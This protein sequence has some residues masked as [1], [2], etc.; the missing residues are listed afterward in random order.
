[1]RLIQWLFGRFRNKPYSLEPTEA[2]R[3]LTDEA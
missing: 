2:G 1:M 3:K